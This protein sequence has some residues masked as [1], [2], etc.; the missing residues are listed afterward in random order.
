MPAFDPSY[1]HAQQRLADFDRL[2]AGVRTWVEALPPWEP[3]DRAK[4]LWGRV[5]PR[6][7]ELQVNLERVLVVGVVGG[8]GTGKSTLINAL[9]GR[10]V[11]EAGDVQRPTTRRPVIVHHTSV[12]PSFLPLAEENPEVHA[13]S[14]PL[15]ENM[16]LVD[17]PDPDTQASD[18]QSSGE[19]RNREILR[20]VLPHC[21]VLIH[22]GTAQK[23][24]TQSVTSELREHAAGRQIVFVQTHAATDADIRPDWRRHLESVG[25]DV[26]MLFR[27]DSEQALRRRE[28]GEPAA[29]EFNELLDF[30]NRELAERGR[31]RIKR[32]NVL[33]LLD[34]YLQTVGRGV[35]AMLPKVHEL[36]QTAM[37][38]QA[39]LFGKVRNRL[40]E[41]LRENRHLW[42]VRLLRQVTQRWSGGPFA[43]FVRLVSSAGSLVRL[44]P[45]AR[46]RGLAPLVIAGGVGA[47][48]AV[49]QQWRE[50]LSSGDWVAAADLGVNQAD[51]AESQ[52]VL[53][54]MAQQAGLQVARPT[55]E[56][57]RSRE[58]AAD[59]SL[60]ALARQL[61][62]HIEYTLADVAEERTRRRAGSLFHLL[63]EVLFCLLPGLLLGR[64]AY[65]FFYEHNWL[66]VTE[67]E[68][69]VKP[70]YGLEYLVQALLWIVVWGLLLRGWLVWRLQRGLTRDIRRMLD[71][72][73][74]ATVL[75]PLFEELR[76]AAR[77]LR[78]QVVLLD[79]FE[80]QTQQLRR[81]LFDESEGW[82]LGRLRS[83]V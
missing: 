59:D 78:E 45:L 60:A 74:P 37:A 20:R 50:S 81:E 13:A 64:L 26:P 44:M 29:P 72:L 77:G 49:V 21:D 43:S 83:A 80:R 48:K 42:R 41:Q 75:G 52:A 55:G 25:F 11:C 58:R 54:G 63:L 36:E 57:S 62:G 73:T 7:S 65:N 61:H 4:A 15:L 5:S 79:S 46:V 40:E 35:Q 71:A 69:V 16:I 2:I 24:K 66:A 82:Q 17:C 33:D 18:E 9:V 68:R 27:I 32:A 12:D 10:R 56:P 38:E 76:A 67:P 47:G 14:L 53:D 70:V 28:R 1:W 51:V 34:W 19:N 31:E 6:L 23:Y 39:R 3:F 8:T 22:V 30:L